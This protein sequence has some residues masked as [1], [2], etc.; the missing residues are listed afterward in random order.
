[1]NTWIDGRPG[2]TIDVRDRGFNYG[3]GAFETMRIRR[4]EIRLLDFH[5][6][7]LD[8]A[9]RRL[10]ILAPGMTG[11]R[12]ELERAASQRQEG[13]V[14]LIVSRG[15]G[16]R[17][18]RPSGRE[19]STRVISVHPL[20][21]RAQPRAPVRVRM[22]FLQ[23]GANPALAGLKTLNRLESVMARAEWTDPGIW[24][25]LLRDSEGHIVCGTMSNLFLRRGRSL[26][27]PRLDRCGIAGVM[28]RWVLAQAR[29]LELEA[30]EARV[31]WR[32]LAG[33]DEAFMTNAVAGVVPVSVIQHGRS[34]LR[35][36]QHGVAHALARRLEPV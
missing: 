13:V 35:L 31:E 33:A 21:P 23:L 3:D 29:A 34:R 27:T 19:R 11:L 32:D 20:P 15:I 26:V 7:R 14:K 6:E 10:Q 24:E 30:R 36:T 5:L 8:H 28:R 1:V 17:G 4:N 9:C 12:R 16:A 2:S 25:G 22:C 18:Y